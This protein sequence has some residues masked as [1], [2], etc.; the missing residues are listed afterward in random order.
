MFEIKEK[1]A[2]KQMEKLKSEARGSKDGVSLSSQAASQQ[3]AKPCYFLQV[4][5][6]LLPLIFTHL[7]VKKIFVICVTCKHMQEGSND[8][9]FWKFRSVSASKITQGT[10]SI[11]VLH[12]ERDG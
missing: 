7:S 9:D 11:L 6:H 8:V 4:P 12:L 5:T 10:N 2:Q 3:P 1:E